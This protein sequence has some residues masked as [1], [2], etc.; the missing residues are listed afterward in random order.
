MNIKKLAIGFVVFFAYYVVSR[1][2]E[3]K[4]AAVRSVIN[5]GQA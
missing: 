5:L 1:I 2:V 3:N 4:V